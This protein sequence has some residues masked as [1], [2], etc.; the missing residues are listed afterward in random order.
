MCTLNYVMN[1]IHSAHYVYTQLYTIKI[2]SVHIVY[3]TAFLKYAHSEYTL[4]ILCAQ[5]VRHSPPELY[6]QA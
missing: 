4:C 2:Y 5:C 1:S 6:T 3:D